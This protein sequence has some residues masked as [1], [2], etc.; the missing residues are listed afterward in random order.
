[1]HARFDAFE[2]TGGVQSFALALVD[3]TT[4]RITLCRD[5]LGIKP[6]YYYFDDKDAVIDELIGRQQVVIKSLGDTMKEIPG[7]AGG[8]IMPNGRVGLI[9]DVGGLVKHANAD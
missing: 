8:A 7:I 5:R 9:L 3:T 4:G 2:D 6:L 1:M